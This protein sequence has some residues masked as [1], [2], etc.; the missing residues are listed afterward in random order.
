MKKY[1][2]SVLAV[3]VLASLIGHA[4]PTTIVGTITDDMCTKKHMMPEKTDSDCVRA[5]V[6]HGAKYVLLA[7]GKA[8][9][10]AG[11][12]A[13]VSELAG[14]RVKVTGDISE[15]TVKIASISELK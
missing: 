9:S 10:L 7:G 2:M 3:L 4:A 5:C 15:G 6:K 8:Y 11:D 1:S 12:T 14:K 13:Q